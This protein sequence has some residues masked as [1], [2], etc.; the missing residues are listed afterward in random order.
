MQKKK[1]NCVANN[2]LVELR[3]QELL[4]HLDFDLLMRRRNGEPYCFFKDHIH[5][6]DDELPPEVIIVVLDA[7]IGHGVTVEAVAIFG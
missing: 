5:L 6:G 1:E 2:L 3:M 4:I 7:D